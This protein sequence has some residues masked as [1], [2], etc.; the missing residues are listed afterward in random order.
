MSEQQ[1]AILLFLLPFA[2]LWVAFVIVEARRALSFNG[3][4]E[5]AE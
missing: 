5:N 2:P 3:S 1:V 4:E